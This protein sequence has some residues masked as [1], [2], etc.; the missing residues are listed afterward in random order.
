MR[1]VKRQAVVEAVVFDETA[2]DNGKQYDG[3]FANPTGY[4]SHV[5]PMIDCEDGYWVLNDGD[6][7]VKS[8]TGFSVMD[9]VEFSL[10]YEPV[11]E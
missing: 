6:Y 5:Q 11:A 10:M 1:Y 3:V 7:I 4:K 2:W 8:D 9:S